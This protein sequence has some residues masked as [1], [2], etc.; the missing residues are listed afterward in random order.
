MRK[1]ICVEICINTGYSLVEHKTVGFCMYV[2][3]HMNVLACD[4][5]E[6]CITRGVMSV[7]GT[8]NK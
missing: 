4:N 3:L 2:Y 7:L 8:D 6:E 5:I 1:E